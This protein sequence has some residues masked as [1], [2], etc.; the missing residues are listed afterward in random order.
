MTIGNSPVY[1]FTRIPFTNANNRFELNESTL[2]ARHSSIQRSNIPIENF[3][4]DIFNLFNLNDDNNRYNCEIMSFS[5]LIESNE[6][7]LNDDVNDI[8]EPKKG[9][10]LH[11]F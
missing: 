7:S 8:I 1:L 6:Q 5:S 11:K 3:I 4:N 10:Q 9:K 2:R